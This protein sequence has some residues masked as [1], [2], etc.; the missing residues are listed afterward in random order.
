MAT[1][2]LKGINMSYTYDLSPETCFED[3]YSQFIAF[4]M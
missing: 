1:S 4:G 3:R 2:E